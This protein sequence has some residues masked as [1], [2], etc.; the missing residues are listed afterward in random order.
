[1]R[2]EKGME[3]V[4]LVRGTALHVFGSNGGMKLCA[5]KQAEMEGSELLDKI[6]ILGKSPRPKMESKAKTAKRQ[7]RAYV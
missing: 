3:G 7:R 6:S 5:R 4:L 1:M 2:V